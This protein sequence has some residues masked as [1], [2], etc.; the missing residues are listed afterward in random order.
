MHGIL[1]TSIKL[2]ACGACAGV[3][4]YLVWFLIDEFYVP[5]P[6]ATPPPPCVLAC[7][8]GG[9][10]IIDRCWC[11]DSY[12]GEL[13]TI[14]NFCR[15][16]RTLQG[17]F[18]FGNILVGMYGYSEERCNATDV[19]ANSSRATIMCRSE[20]G[21]PELGSL[22]LQTCTDNLETLASKTNIDTENAKEI[23]VTTQILTA[24]PENLE[25]D[26]ISNAIT[27]VSRLLSVSTNAS[28]DQEVAISAITTVSQIISAESDKF[29]DKVVEE[30]RNLT[31]A[32]ETFSQSNSTPSLSLVQPSIAVETRQLSPLNFSGISFMS[33]RGLEDNLVSSRI[34]VDNDTSEFVLNETAEVQIFVKPVGEVSNSSTIG[35]IL[36]QNDNLF[37]SKH[38]QKTGFRK[39]VI[40]ASSSGVSVNVEFSF[41]QQVN[42]SYSLVQYACVFWDYESGDWN[43]TGCEKGISNQT[44]NETS[45]SSIKP[46]RCTCLHTTNFAVLMKFKENIDFVS[47]DIVSTIGCALSVTGLT[48]T[49]IFLFYA[50]NKKPV[51]WILISFCLSLLIFYIV[52]ITAMEMSKYTVVT[53]EPDYNETENTVFWSDLVIMYD[54]LCTGL[55]ALQH[56][57]LLATF[58]LMGLLG[59]EFYYRI[60]SASHFL[61]RH[62][63]KIALITGWGLPAVIVTITI[64]ATYPNENNYN[65]KE[66]CWLLA[67]NK[68]NKFDI[69]KPMLWS[70][71]VPVGLILIFNICTVIG[72]VVTIWKRRPELTRSTR[73]SFLK[74]ILATFSVVSL[75]GVTWVFGYLTLIETDDNTHLVF[76]FIYCLCCSTQ[77]IQIFA[78]YTLRS[79]LFLKKVIYV[80]RKFNS[81]KGYI[82]SQTYRVTRMAERTTRRHHER[83]RNLSDSNVELFADEM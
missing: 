21:K 46:L 48:V 15:P 7:Q 61:P 69:S 78:F 58:V 19:N 50:R 52:F 64:A 72:V 51:S 49:V 62:F 23:A 65:R 68:N 60:I 75:L 44:S 81:C 16:N 10:C 17:N 35:F 11:P 9:S 22:I 2:I 82:H 28:E 66:F 39:K 59:A 1:R 76:S 29:N 38:K 55:A 37:S 41:N 4:T 80:I 74:K 18:T 30:A 31:M 32:M 79:P 56:Y 12:T 45:S 25:T 77:G 67:E 27:I 5:P 14:E 26:D 8:N 73:L 24:E 47:L 53:A 40:S 36:Y 43:T 6:P 13:C 71:L 34:I 57:F 20:G 33:L 83:F 54:G 42:E 70:F 63:M 3:V